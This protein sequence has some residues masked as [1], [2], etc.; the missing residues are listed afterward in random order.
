MQLS[1]VGEAKESWSEHLDR[2]LCFCCSL[3]C[4][5]TLVNLSLDDINLQ[6]LHCSSRTASL[7]LSCRHI[8][9]TNVARRP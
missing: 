3:D 6:L 9:T 2:F 8:S 5:S 7:D 4:T 1:D